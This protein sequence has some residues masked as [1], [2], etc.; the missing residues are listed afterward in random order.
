VITSSSWRTPYSKLWRV[1]GQWE[2]QAIFREEEY[3]EFSHLSQDK[4]VGTQADGVAT[5]YDVATGQQT[6]ILK[7]TTYNS[8]SRNRATFDP[9]DSL[10]LSDGVLWDYRDP[11]V[12]H[13]FDKLNQTLSGAFH[14]NGLEI[15]SN[16]EIWDIRTFHLLRTVPQLDQCQIV[17]NNTGDII[18]GIHLEQ[19]LEDETYFEKSFKTFEASDYS[20][21]STVNTRKGVL[22]LCTS[23]DDLSLAVVE[24]V[25]GD[26]TESVVR[27]Y[28]VGCVRMEEEDQE[29][30]GED[31]DG[32]QDNDDDSDSDGGPGLDD[33]GLPIP[34]FSDVDDMSGSGTGSED[35]GDDEVDLDD[36]EDL[37]ESV[38]VEDGDEDDDNSWEDIDVEEEVGG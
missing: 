24:Q 3:L 28:D 9:T 17:F 14:P 35:D 4:M 16:T 19:E 26:T 10:V 13:K 15:I 25:Q 12:I 20:L 33:W 21:I 23:R 18:F 1:G 30:D 6:C 2:E 34:M 38:T 5:I 27:L 29:D 22:G 31:D 7:P 32:G 36:D 8:Y 37:A 11:K